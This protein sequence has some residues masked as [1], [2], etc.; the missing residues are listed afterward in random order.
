MNA[1][2]HHLLDLAKIEAGRFDLTRTV[3]QASRSM[4]DVVTIVAPL[5]EAK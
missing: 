1:L 3:C 5:A 4:S 2:I